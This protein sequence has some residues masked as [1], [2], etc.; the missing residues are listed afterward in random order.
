MYIFFDTI[1]HHSLLLYDHSPC[2]VRVEFTNCIFHISRSSNTFISS[3]RQ[4]S[5]WLNMY[6]FHLQRA[7]LWSVGAIFVL[8]A[9]SNIYQY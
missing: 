5:V 7:S 3:S 4:M 6:T 9:I 1:Q 8:Y 2:L